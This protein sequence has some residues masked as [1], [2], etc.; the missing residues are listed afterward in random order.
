MLHDM[1]LALRRVLRTPGISLAVIVILAIGIGAAT[2]MTSVL[3][4]LSYRPLS[5]P[6]PQSLVAVT[7]V[8][9]RGGTRITPLPTITGLRSAGLVADGWC[10]HNSI[11]ESVSG[12]ERMLRGWV[13]LMAGD[14]AKVI[15]IE[16]VIG[17]WFSTEETPLTGK[18]Q[19]V[20][21]ISDR[22]WQRMFDRSPD[23][24]GQGIQIQDVTATVIGVLPPA[25]T[26]FDAATAT[27]LVIPFN[28]HRQASGGLRYMGRLRRGATIEQLNAQ[29]TALW[30]SMLEAVQPAG[31]TRAQSLQEWRGDAQAVP[32]GFS[33]LRRLYATPV[34]NLA[35]LTVALLTLVCVNVSALLISRFT[36]RAQE[37]WAMRALGANATRLVRPLAIEGGLLAGGGALLGVP[38]AYAAS[39]SFASLFPTGNTPWTLA[40]TPDRLVLVAVTIGLIGV[41]AMISAIPIWLAVRRPHA[42][43]HQ[44]TAS[45]ATSRWAQAML[46]SQIAV[47]IVLVFT[48][49]LVMRSFYGLITV[50]RGYNADRLLSLRLGVTPGGYRGLDPPTYYPALVQRLAALPGVQSV[51]LARYFGT[52]NA[53][54]TEQPVGFIEIDDNAASAAMDFVSPGFFSTIGA[55]LLAGRDVAWSDLPATPRVAVVSESVAR[56]LAPDGSVIG[57][58]IRYGTTPAYARLQIVGV[59]GNISIGNLRK[60]DERM[61]YTSSVQVGETVSASVHM[62]TAGPPL[63]TA[64]AASQAVAAMGREHVTGAYSDMLFGNSIVA[65]RMGTAVSAVVALLALS[66]SCIGVFALLSHSVQRRTREIGIRV[67]V[68]ATPAAISTLVMRDALILI[69]CGLAVGIPGALAATKLVQSLLYEVTAADPVTLTASVAVL[70]ITALLAAVRPTQRAVGV[71]PVAAL[72]AE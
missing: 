39:A 45:R 8:D 43:E 66:I 24:L 5:L 10:A 61:I 50:D 35:L 3:Y 7:T 4:A 41:A 18:G 60:T 48:C 17:R 40:T 16:P 19:P 37:M 51:G 64:Q 46:V 32:Q 15:G 56:Q 30:P 72:R 58:T 54:M 34:R 53:Q 22:F 67:A 49:G 52:I 70:S 55:P 36:G 6:D 12:N 11:V 42:V 9:R 44:R 33:I 71:D 28:A 57:R 14:C 26:G 59:V 68:G 27:D 20:V 47:A 38:L 29:I 65:E 31:L 62:R 13:D 21:V 63:Q 23:V 25:F 1:R 69:G 2:T